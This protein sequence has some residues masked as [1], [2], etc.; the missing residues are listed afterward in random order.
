MS[1]RAARSDLQETEKLKFFSPMRKTDSAESV[2]NGCWG[3]YLDIG[4]ILL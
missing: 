1:K 3:T 2:V 4:R